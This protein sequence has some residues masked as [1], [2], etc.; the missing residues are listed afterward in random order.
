MKKLFA[1][2]LAVSLLLCGC[3]A[4]PETVP[5][6]GTAPTEQRNHQ[7]LTAENGAFDREKDLRMDVPQIGLTNVFVRDC[8]P[9]IWLDGDVWGEVYLLADDRMGYYKAD[10]YLLVTTKDSFAAVDLWEENTAG[11]LGGEITTADV[12]GDGDE[13][14]LVQETVDAFGGAGQYRSWVFD[15]KDGE[16][17]EMFCSVKNGEL[18]DTGFSVKLLEKKQF[19]I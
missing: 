12:D 7:S 3:G 9:H 1:I 15:Y 2:I 8:S 10:H 13:E 6:D 11:N 14:I 5:T 17:K 19:E 16:I 18:V 4:V